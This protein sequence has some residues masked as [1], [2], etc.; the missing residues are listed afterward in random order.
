MVSDL[1]GL[2]SEVRPPLTTRACNEFKGTRVW[3]ACVSA[4]ACRRY[5]VMSQPGSATA[6]AVSMAWHRAQ[7]TVQLHSVE[8]L[9]PKRCLCRHAGL[10]GTDTAVRLPGARIA[11][12][13]QLQQ[14]HIG[15]SSTPSNGILALAQDLS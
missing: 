7:R 10:Q 4:R 5:I 9:K 2:R 3:V 11:A 15:T 6:I 8:L 14:P 13:R 12:Y 1:I